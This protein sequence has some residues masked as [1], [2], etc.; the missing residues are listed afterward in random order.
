MSTATVTKPHY[1]VGQTV[2]YHLMKRMDTGNYEL[3]PITAVLDRYD[4]AVI[5]RAEG[6]E[7]SEPG[8][9]D[10][11]ADNQDTAHTMVNGGSLAVAVNPDNQAA[12]DHER[13][14]Y[15]DCFGE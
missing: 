12:L 1:E 11:I 4:Y 5:L 9:V 7:C 13:A 10:D 3:R 15:V 2:H 8:C 14:L 6:P